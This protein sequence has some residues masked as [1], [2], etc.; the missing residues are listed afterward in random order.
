[1][2]LHRIVARL[3]VRPLLTLTACVMLLPLAGCASSRPSPAALDTRNDV[4]SHCRMA[5]SDARFAAQIVAPGEEPRFFDDVGCL[6][7]YL[8]GGNA[9]APGSA[10]FVASYQTRAWI[11]AGEAVYLKDE[12]IET[13]MGFHYVAFADAAERDS[14]PA[15]RS[16]AKL[17]AAEVF[18]AGLP[19]EVSR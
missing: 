4:C 8:E 10:V 18:G 19:G 3:G 5:V 14:H 9:L 7:A 17:G 12:S 2:S 16:G 15:A 1:M 6:R 13:P 11:P